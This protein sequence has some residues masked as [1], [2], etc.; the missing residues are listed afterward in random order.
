[1]RSPVALTVLPSPPLGSGPTPSFACI[2]AL[3]APESGWINGQRIEVSGGLVHYREEF[4]DPSLQAA[5]QDYQLE[6][7]GTQYFNSG[8]LVPLGVSFIQETTVFREYGPL[9]GSTIRSQS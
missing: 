3:T 9:S 5:S 1:M 7:Y 6:A 4:A 8:L 2:D